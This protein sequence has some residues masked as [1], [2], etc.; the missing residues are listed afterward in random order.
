[1]HAYIALC[2]ATGIRTEEARALLPIADYSHLR[3]CVRSLIQPPP[4]TSGYEDQAEEGRRARGSGPLER[5]RGPR[6]V[7]SDPDASGLTMIYLAGKL[8]A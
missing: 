8:L 7:G 3:R 2:L 6:S 4:R 1:M 5:H